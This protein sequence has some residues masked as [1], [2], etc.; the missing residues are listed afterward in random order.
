[1]RNPSQNAGSSGQDDM[2]WVDICFVRIVR[3]S[4]NYVPILRWKSKLM[5]KS[6]VTLRD[7]TQKIVHCLGRSVI[8]LTPEVVDPTI[9]D[10]WDND[11]AD[12]KQK[13]KLH[14][15]VH[16]GTPHSGK[17]NIAMENGPGLKMYFLLKMVIYSSLGVP[18]V[19]FREVF[20]GQLEGTSHEFGKLQICV[21]LLGQWLNFK[22]FGITHLVGKIEFKLLF[23]GSI[24]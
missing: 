16:P 17:L 1:M 14:L 4:L 24:G 12:S 23:Q 19:S 2:T 20:V 18:A 15:I 22:L 8:F 5:P 6:M 9:E 7:L 10:F 21:V 3:G 13:K 11:S